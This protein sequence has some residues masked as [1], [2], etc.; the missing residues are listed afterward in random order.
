[1]WKNIIVIREII[2]GIISLINMLKTAQK[3]HKK[4]KL[5]E[6]IEKRKNIMTEIGLKAAEEPSKENDEELIAL[7]NKLYGIK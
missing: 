4:K 1:M 2:L 3:K 6:L 5:D 7:Y